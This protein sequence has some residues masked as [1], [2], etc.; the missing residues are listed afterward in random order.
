MPTITFDSLYENKVRTGLIDLCKIDIEGAEYEFLSP[1][2]SQC[3]NK[4][5]YLLIEIHG[6]RS[7]NPQQLIENIVS[8]G[9]VTLIAGNSI[10]PEVFL[11]ENTSLN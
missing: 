1:K 9:F 2:S 8:R 6:N 10:S 4:I 11:F 5:K 7:G 3:L